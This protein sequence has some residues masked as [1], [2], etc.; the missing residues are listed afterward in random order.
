MLC[1]NDAKIIEAT[2]G[3]CPYKARVCDGLCNNCP[4]GAELA[5]PKNYKP[6]CYFVP[7]KRNSVSWDELDYLEDRCLGDIID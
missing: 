6:Q 7:S 3:K 1:E 2:Q 4:K 5:R